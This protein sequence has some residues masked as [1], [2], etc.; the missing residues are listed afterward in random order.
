MSAVI[1]RIDI[2]FEQPVFFQKPELKKLHDFWKFTEVEW[3]QYWQESQVKQMIL[4]ESLKN[5]LHR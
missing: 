3:N 5:I 4:K 1:D 2:P